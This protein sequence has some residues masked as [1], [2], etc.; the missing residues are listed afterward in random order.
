L[1]RSESKS[2]HSSS[3]TTATSLL[4]PQGK[5]EKESKIKSG[6]SLSHAESSGCSSRQPCLH[7][8]SQGKFGSKKPFGDYMHGTAMVLLLLVLE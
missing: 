4:P 5:Q 6:S 3:V 7:R 1:A 8:S 2:G